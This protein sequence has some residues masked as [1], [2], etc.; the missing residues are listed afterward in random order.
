MRDALSRSFAR[1]HRLLFQLAHK[2]STRFLLQ[3][4]ISTTTQLHPPHNSQRLFSRSAKMEFDPASYP[5]F[6]SGL[7]SV[8]LETYRLADI[9]N[10][11]PDVEQKLFETCKS[12]GFFYLDFTGS[13]AGDM[14]QDAEAIGRL[15]EDVFKLPLEEKE[16]YPMENSIFGLVPCLPVLSIS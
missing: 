1:Q 8:E 4:S 5:T 12:R 6:P 10:G 9:E 16:K 2:G 15:A 11:D 13:S 7:P 3:G 14:Q